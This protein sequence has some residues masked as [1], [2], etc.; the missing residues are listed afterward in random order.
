MYSSGGLERSKTVTVNSN[1]DYTEDGN[2]NSKH[3]P[4]VKVVNSTLKYGEECWS[5]VWSKWNLSLWDET[6]IQIVLLKDLVNIMI[7][8]S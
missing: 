2:G 1:D 3:Y 5:L 8:S 6:I 7:K 4:I